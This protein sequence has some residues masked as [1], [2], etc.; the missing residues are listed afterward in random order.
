M[1][2]SLENSHLEISNKQDDGKFSPGYIDDFMN[3]LKVFFIG[4]LVLPSIHMKR[5]YLFF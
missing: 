1:C 2:C 5:R 4:G 3:E